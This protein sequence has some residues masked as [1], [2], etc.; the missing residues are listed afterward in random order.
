[1]NLNNVSLESIAA[2]KVRKTVPLENLQAVCREAGRERYGGTQPRLRCPTFWSNQQS[3]SRNYRRYPYV[4]L[5]GHSV[6]VRFQGF[7]D[8]L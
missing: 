2:K 6:G 4:Y 5:N 8:P 3:Q 1:M 7:G